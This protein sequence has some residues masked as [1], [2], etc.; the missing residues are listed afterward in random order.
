MALKVNLQTSAYGFSFSEAY[1]RITEIFI[2]KSTT[3]FQIGIHANEDARI[4]YARQLETRL[5]SI[6]TDD[7]DSKILPF[8]YNYLKTLPEFQ[9]AEDV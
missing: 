8:L 2:N 9:G 7:I 5:Y 3:T 1:V 6:N 4:Q